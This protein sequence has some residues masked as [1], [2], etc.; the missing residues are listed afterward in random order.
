MLVEL[1][2]IASAIALVSGIAAVGNGHRFNYETKDIL[3][4]RADAVLY[5]WVTLSSIFALAHL[6]ALVSFGLRFHWHNR[7]DTTTLWMLLHTGIAMLLTSAHFYI[8]H[9][10]SDPFSRVAYLWGKNRHVRSA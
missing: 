2:T 5:V 9:E 4:G 7:D 8:K 10:L 6:S 1:A 3:A